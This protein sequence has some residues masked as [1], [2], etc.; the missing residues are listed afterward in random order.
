[1]ILRRKTPPA[2][3]VTM[4]WRTFLHIRQGTRANTQVDTEEEATSQE[5]E[6]HWPP[7]G[8]LQRQTSRASEQLLYMYQQ[9]NNES[10]S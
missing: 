6:G 8:R 5:T 10:L 2:L 4:I 3:A 1:M 7:T 9:M